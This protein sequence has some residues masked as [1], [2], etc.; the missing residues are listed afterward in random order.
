[1]TDLVLVLITAALTALGTTLIKDWLPSLVRNTYHQLTRQKIMIVEIKSK[2][3][4]VSGVTIAVTATD[5]DRII[6][7]GTTNQSGIARLRGISA[8]LIPVEATLREGPYERRYVKIQKVESLPFYLPLDQDRDF[9][10]PVYV[11]VV[12]PPPPF[13][14][15]SQPLQVEYGEPLLPVDRQI[16]AMLQIDWVAGTSRPELQVETSAGI[17]RIEDIF[18]EVGISLEVRWGNELPVSR[19]GRDGRFSVKE[20]G[21]TNKLYR[22]D[23]PPDTWPFYL[24]YGGRFETDGVLSIM[25]DQDRQ[26]AV[27]FAAEVMSQPHDPRDTLHL[28]VHE[29]GHMLNLPH[30]WQV[31]GDTRSVM[32]Y[33]WRWSD[34]SLDDPDVYRFDSFGQQHIRRAPDHYVQPGGSPFLDYG[35]P[36][37]ILGEQG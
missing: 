30:P 3:Q 6:A 10:L 33:P 35:R 18:R 22:D 34:W 2:R 21:D 14:T 19:M 9:G 27:V 8:G 26:G 23:A 20:L 28:I 4:P 24:I 16:S 25:F 12:T 13:P 7:S 11:A 1:M 32:S 36:I 31:Y 5:S 17:L 29:M 37:P 15:P